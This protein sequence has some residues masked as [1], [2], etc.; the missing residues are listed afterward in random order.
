MSEDLT[1][2]RW[3][4]PA[5]DLEERFDTPGGPGGQH[6]NR[7]STAVTLRLWIPGSSL[8]EPVRRRLTARLGEMVEVR[9]ADTR[10]QSR[11]R[12]LARER[13]GERLGRALVMAPKRKPTK[14]TRG[15]VERRLSEKRARSEIKRRRRNPDRF[16]GA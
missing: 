9:V 8:P 4:I 15:S 10:S 13:L 7:S 12:A 2:G 16:E 5:G 3:T 6:A 1:V 14:P 11:N